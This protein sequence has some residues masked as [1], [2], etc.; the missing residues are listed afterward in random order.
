MYTHYFKINIKIYY[1]YLKCL[2]F[3]SLKAQLILDW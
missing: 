1:I 2:D 3:I